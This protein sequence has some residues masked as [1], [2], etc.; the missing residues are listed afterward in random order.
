M[1][2]LDPRNATDWLILYA[3]TAVDEPMSERMEQVIELMFADVKQ[4][5]PAP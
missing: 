5:D 3:V 4:K 2:L 1:P